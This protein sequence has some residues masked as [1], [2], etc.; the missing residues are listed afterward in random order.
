MRA[1]SKVKRPAQM[2]VIPELPVQLPKLMHPVSMGAIPKV[3]LPA[4]IPGIRK[5]TGGL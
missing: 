2:Q 3:I 4:Q 5:E 1:I